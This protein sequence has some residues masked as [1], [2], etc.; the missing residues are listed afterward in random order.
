MYTYTCKACTYTLQRAQNQMHG[1]TAAKEI[2]RS[3]NRIVRQT[4]Q[5]LGLLTCSRAVIPC[6]IPEREPNQRDKLPCGSELNACSRVLH[7]MHARS[8]TKEKRHTGKRPNRFVVMYNP[9]RGHQTESHRTLGMLPVAMPC[10]TPC[11]ETSCD[12]SLLARVN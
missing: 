6:T 10:T 3:C 12:V 2:V 4:D 5:L 7:G 8:Q 1:T 9:C 11:S